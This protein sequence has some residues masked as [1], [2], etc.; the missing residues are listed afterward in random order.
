MYSILEQSSTLT[1]QNVSRLNFP[2]E[3]KRD[4]SLPQDS[5]LA[6]GPTL[7]PTE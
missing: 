5:R 3:K 2:A 6:L 4:F 1:A 7:S